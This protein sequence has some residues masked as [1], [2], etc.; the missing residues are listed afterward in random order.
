MNQLFAN[1][2]ALNEAILI[3]CDEAGRGALAGP[4]VVAACILPADA[5]H[6]DL[7]DSKLLSAPKRE[8]L[9][10]WIREV[11]V[12]FSVIEIDNTTIDRVNIL[13][14]TLLGMKLAIE[15]LNRESALC[16]I[17]GISKPLITNPLRTVIKGDSTHACIAA[18]S[19][20][21]KVHRDRLMKHLHESYPVYK[22]ISNKGYGSKEHLE[23]LA[24]YGPCPVHRYS[25]SPVAQTNIWQNLSEKG[26]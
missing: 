7:N 13:Q 14:A 17:D 8:K 10:A 22:F 18:A 5:Y 6:E 26:C 19:I 4:V 9:D 25:Y 21:A 11:A 2:L 12:D 3:G 1:D 23:A 20:L 16:L 15:K 24:E